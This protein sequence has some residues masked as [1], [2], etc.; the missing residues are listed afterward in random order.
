MQ[1]VF[2][3]TSWI[4]KAPKCVDAPRK[5]GKNLKIEQCGFNPESVEAISL[6]C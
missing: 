3:I 4:H 6:Q 5:Y 1:S 2:K